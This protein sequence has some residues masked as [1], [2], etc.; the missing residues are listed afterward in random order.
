MPHLPWARHFVP[1][2]ADEL[3]ASERTAECLGLVSVEMGYALET[4]ARTIWG[5]AR[6]EGKLGI[7]PSG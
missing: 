2:S 5:E 3:A 7:N 4:L 1:E 6:G